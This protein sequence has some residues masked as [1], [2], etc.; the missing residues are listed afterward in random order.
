MFCLLSLLALFPKLCSL[1]ELG[2][3]GGLCP[4]F[5]FHFADEVLTFQGARVADEVPD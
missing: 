3:D 5:F 4:W 1:G 2:F